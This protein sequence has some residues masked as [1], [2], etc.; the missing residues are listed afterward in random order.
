M[1]GMFLTGILLLWQNFNRSAVGLSDAIKT[2]AIREGV[3]M[4]T[5]F[6]IEGISVDAQ[7]CSIVIEVKNSGSEPISPISN[8]AMM[9]S[10]SQGANE[11]RVLEHRKNVEAFTPD[12]WTILES[13]AGGHQPVILYPGTSA[14]LRIAMD[15]AQP[16]DTD[17]SVIIA[18]PNGVTT[19]ALVSGI[20]TPCLATA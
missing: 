10:F 4:R 3:R 19:T 1:M 17:A 14:S 20:S 12:T 11:P 6:D 5:A 16:G 8:L 18:T 2:S 13:Q 9:I 15:L 7:S